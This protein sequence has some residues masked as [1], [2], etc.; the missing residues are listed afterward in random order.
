MQDGRAQD[1][2]ISCKELKHKGP[3]GLLWVTFRTSTN[4]ILHTFAEHGSC[5]F[6]SLWVL[7]GSSFMESFQMWT[8][9]QVNG[10]SKSIHRRPRNNSRQYLGAHWPNNMSFGS[11]TACF[12]IHCCRNAITYPYGEHTSLERSEVL[13]E[14]LSGIKARRW[15]CP[16]PCSSSPVI[17]G[18]NDM[19]PA[20][21]KQRLIQA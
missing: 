3:Q 10:P 21:L 7:Y 15:K 14:A 16:M 9:T 6:G 20:H 19:R 8:S 4:P 18:T 1:H 12:C 2:N 17:V 13:F 11:E 5:R